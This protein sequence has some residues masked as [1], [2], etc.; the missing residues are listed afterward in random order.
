[1]LHEID[2]AMAWILLWSLLMYVTW[3]DKAMACI[4][5]YLNIFLWI[6]LLL[7]GNLFEN[8]IY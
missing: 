6:N 8:F 4:L 3:S 1:L 2:K 5:V 7:F